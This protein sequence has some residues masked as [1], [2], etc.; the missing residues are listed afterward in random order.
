[1]NDKLYYVIKST[2]L[3]QEH[4]EVLKSDKKIS[5]YVKNDDYIIY[6]KERD[7]FF[8]FNLTPSVR[9]LSEVYTDSNQF[10]ERVAQYQLN[11]TLGLTDEQL[12]ILR[13]CN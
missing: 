3:N 4:L 10:M 6:C 5:P 2:D 8:L 9:T 7:Y 1:M 12:S 11:R 13:Y